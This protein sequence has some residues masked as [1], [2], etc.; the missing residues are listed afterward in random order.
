MFLCYPLGRVDAPFRHWS[1][2]QW[3][4]PFVFNFSAAFLNDLLYAMPV[5]GNVH[6]L[7]IALALFVYKIIRSRVWYTIPSVLKRKKNE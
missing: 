7:F 5:G 4:E 1:F 3:T 2:A 6:E